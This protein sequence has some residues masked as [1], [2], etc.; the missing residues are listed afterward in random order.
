MKGCVNEYSDCTVDDIVEKYIE[1]TPEVGSVGVYVD[2]TNR[3]KKSTDVIKGSNNEDSTMFALTQ[4]HRNLRTAQN[5][6]GRSH[7]SDYQC[8]STDKIQAGIPIDETGNLLL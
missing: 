6:T 5:R 1:G 3:P 8:G 7:S 2:D 4:S